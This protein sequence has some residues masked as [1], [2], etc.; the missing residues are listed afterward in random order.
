MT[1]NEVRTA[2]AGTLLDNSRVVTTDQLK[3]SMIYI[4]SSYPPTARKDPEGCQA[5]HLIPSPGSG[6]GVNV[7]KCVPV[8]VN[9]HNLY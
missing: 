6:V 1:R 2:A 3:D 8:S 5:T 7:D 4:L 9:M